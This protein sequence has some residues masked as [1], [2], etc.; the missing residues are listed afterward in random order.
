VIEIRTVGGPAV[1]PWLG[2][3]AAL[4]IEVFR[5]WPYLYDGDF[6]YEAKYL[7]TYARAPHSL[8]VLA[9][10]GA[11]VIGASTGVP[12]VDEVEAFHRPFRAAGIDAREV[13]YFGESV[14]LASY[15]GRGLGHRFF[16][17]REAHARALDRFR[18]TA[19][20]AVVRAADDP[21]RPADHRPLDAFW[22]GRGYRPRADMVA[23]IEWQELGECAPSRKP[24]S[25]W[26]RPLD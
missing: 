3:V 23:E 7:A 13:Y 6:D 19:F 10:D 24:L 16:D 14:L 5:A 11:Q 2:A 8:F 20:C 26:M 22:R 25:F 17:E 12:L 9:L 15:R 18:W 1:G 21:R 4:R